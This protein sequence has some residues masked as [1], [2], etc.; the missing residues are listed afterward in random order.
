MDRRIPT[1]WRNRCDDGGGIRALGEEVAEDAATTKLMRGIGK[2]IH[3]MGSPFEQPLG[4][5]SG[6]GTR[7][8]PRIADRSNGFVQQRLQPELTTE[9]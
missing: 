7:A 3:L 1:L 9:R 4:N 6:I 5:R 8:K 2:K